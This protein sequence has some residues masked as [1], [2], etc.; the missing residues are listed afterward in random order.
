MGRGFREVKVKPLAEDHIRALVEQAYRHIYRTDPMAQ[1]KKSA[2]LLAGIEHLESER[3][4]RLGEDAP[5]LVDSPL[6]VRLL[7]I[8]HY[9]ERRRLPEQRAELYMKAT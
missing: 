1:A 7:L 5:R 2:E 4:R 3:Q 9:S 6:L 8:V